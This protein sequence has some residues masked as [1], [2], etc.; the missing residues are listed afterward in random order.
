MMKNNIYNSSE[1][2]RPKSGYYIK[3]RVNP[4]L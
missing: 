2:K 1:K 4:E 3:L